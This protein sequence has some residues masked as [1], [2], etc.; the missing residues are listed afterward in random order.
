MSI[1]RVCESVGEMEELA[2]R[3]A[4]GDFFPVPPG[5]IILLEGEVG[6]GKT[7][8]VR[9]FASYY[10]LEDF[11][12]SPTFSLIHE[13]TDGEVRILHADLYRLTRAEEIED[14]GLW[15]NLENAKALLIEWP[16]AAGLEPSVPFIRVEIRYGDHETQRR[17]SISP[18][19]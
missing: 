7:A 10:G 11:V 2:R 19:A 9:G 1:E 5:S 16:S 18:A 12:L 15:E 17:V 6:A 4:G 8:F 13:Y 14:L 3:F